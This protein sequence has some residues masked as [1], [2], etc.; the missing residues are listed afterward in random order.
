[1][2]I[3]TQKLILETDSQVVAAK[4]NNDANDLSIYGPM[5]EEVKWLIRLTRNLQG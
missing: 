1:M 5:T 4:M 3:G 2:E